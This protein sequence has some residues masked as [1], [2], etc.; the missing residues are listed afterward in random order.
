MNK[1]TLI[2]L[3]VVTLL[4]FGAIIGG[5]LA[6]YGG[7]SKE[8]GSSIAG[9]Q[10]EQVESVEP[11][12][13][14]D[15]TVDRALAKAD[16]AA[17]RA[18]RK[19]AREAERAAKK[20]AREAEKAAAAER[21]A[22]E[23]AAREAEKAAAAEPE[24]TTPA[25]AEA[26]EPESAATEAT[27][28]EPERAEKVK[29]LATRDISDL[30]EA[31]AED[32]ACV[33]TYS[34]MK[35]AS[36]LLGDST[37]VYSALA[38]DAQ[39]GSVLDFVTGLRG[40]CPGSGLNDARAL[41]SLHYSGNLVP[42]LVCDAAHVRDSAAV[43]AFAAE[44]GAVSRFHHAD[45]GHHYLLVSTSATLVTASIRHIDESSSVYEQPEFKQCLE[46]LPGEDR[47]IWANE[48]AGKLLGSYMTRKYSANSGFLRKA[49]VWTGVGVSDN[50]PTRALLDGV[51]VVPG[52]DAAA[53]V[54]VLKDLKPATPAAGK[55]LPGGT[56]FAVSLPM[57]D[58]KAA[59][60]RYLSYL[61]ASMQ[62]PSYQ[63]SSASLK[64]VTGR[65]PEEWIRE[66]SPKELVYAC[67]RDAEG[68]ELEAVLLRPGKSRRKASQTPEQ[69]AFQGYAG[70]S[71]GEI[72]SIGD[73][74][75]CANVGGWIVSGSE[76]AVADLMDAYAQGD[77]LKSAFPDAQ[78]NAAAYV[79]L[80]DCAIDK[81]FR[82]PLSVAVKR[83]LLGSAAE[84]A[85]L[86]VKGDVLSVEVLRRAESLTIRKSEAAPTYT[87]D[88]PKGPFEV[89]NCQTGKKNKLYQNS[90]LSIVLQDE[91]GKDVWGVPF[92]E[93]ICGMVQEVDYYANGKIQFL[94]AA[95]S[96][97][98]LIDRLSHVVRDFPAEL[99][100]EVLL[101]PAVYDFTGAH[102]Y[103]ALVLHK[104]NTIGMYNL[105]GKAPADWKGIAPEE[106][107]S[108]LPEL[109][110]IKGSKYWLVPTVI[111]EVLYPFYGGERVKD[112]KILNQIKKK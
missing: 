65:K 108:G 57:A 103:T 42:L 102:G 16:R 9:P 1:K 36:E 26:T 56:V 31:V 21:K 90:H 81:V 39:S 22:S 78:C 96:K 80:G 43:S 19:A 92:K 52:S 99:G 87:I 3:T 29:A 82:A 32:A 63:Q 86:L 8:A 110:E 93:R 84:T 76:A 98:Y 61:D 4:L 35:K 70:T 5:L 68:N 89:T 53:Y 55:V 41:V 59:H 37:K 83:S 50:S 27:K 106:M 104:D 66:V 17:A 40:A 72:F 44:C 47:I 13:Q 107:I 62:M 60:K 2:L 91:N 33:F 58:A 88:I 7:A 28:P 18:E 112:K 73:E 48:Y 71:F 15:G 69:Y 30:L 67:W 24:A 6:L 75:C 12:A 111:Q 49:A 11:A 10:T 100:K 54:N 14:T 23:K 79:S 77:V 101:G 38:C 25:T 94:F 95:G 34:S 74:S 64:A 46:A 85:S 51:A 97:L 45:N 20:A 109:V 105:H